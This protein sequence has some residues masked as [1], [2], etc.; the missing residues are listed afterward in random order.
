MKLNTTHRLRIITLEISRCAL[1]I[2]FPFGQIP[3]PT[4]APLPHTHAQFIA[5]IKQLKQLRIVGFHLEPDF[6]KG[7]GRFTQLTH[8][9]IH[10]CSLVQG[11]ESWC[12]CMWPTEDLVPHLE[13]LANNLSKLTQL[14]H[15]ELELEIEDDGGEPDKS[16]KSAA[17]QPLVQAVS[18]LPNAERVYVSLVEPPWQRTVLLIGKKPS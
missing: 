13:V 8:L 14:Q 12:S 10:S 9:A 3:P 16:W 15:L 7:L 4:Y 11:W 18:G 6:I 2:S 1:E 5:G 17:C